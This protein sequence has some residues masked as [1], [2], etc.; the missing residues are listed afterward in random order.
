MN[1]HEEMNVAKF[2]DW[3]SKVI[4]IIEEN[5]VVVMDNAPYHSRKIDKISTSKWKKADIQQWLR[6]RG[7]T[8]ADDIIKIELLHIMK[9]Q[10]VP[11]NYA[12]DEIVK[13]KNV[14]ILRLLPY[15]C[16][17]NPIQMIWTQ[18]TNYV[19]TRNTT[20]KFNDMTRFF[21]EAVNNVIADNWKTCIDHVVINF[22]DKFLQLDGI[23]E[24]VIEP[25]ITN[26]NDSDDTSSSANTSSE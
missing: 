1:Y 8:F 13:R 19:A 25:F 16:E 20:F 2:E 22:E 24:S 14:T 21:T 7:I 15:H 23:I 17:L 4:S 6:A 11:D 3:F 12:V 18:V 9:Q 10:Q 26:L 5:S